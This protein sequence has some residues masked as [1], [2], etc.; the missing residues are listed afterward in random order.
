LTTAGG[1]QCWG[2]NS[3]G[4]LGNNST[5]NSPVPVAVSG[6][7]SGVL[8]VSAGWNHACA[9]TTAGGV[10]CW[11]DNE[12]GELGNNST[13][14]SPV[15]VV[16]SGLSS[17]VAAVSTGDY[18]T[19]AVTT[20]GGVWCWGDNYYGQLGNNS[21]TN[22]HVPVAVSGLSSGVAAVSTGRSHTCALT[23]ARTVQC[24][25]DNRNGELGNNSTTQS[26]VPVAVSGLPSDIFAVSARAWYTC[27]VNGNGGVAGAIQCWGQNTFGQLGNNSTTDSHVP[28]WVVEP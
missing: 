21:T 20:A 22:S 26:L 7:S 17:G 4:Q 27:A 5:T 11:G 8:A 3:N 6:L 24:W 10:R 12:F 14:Q 15:P 1:V 9:V 25:G 16:V 19:C 2:N 28:V 13:M 18:Y 23:T